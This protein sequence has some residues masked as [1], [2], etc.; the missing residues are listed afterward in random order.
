MV[1]EIDV[2]TPSGLVVTSVITTRSVRDLGLV[3]GKKSLPWS[4]PPRSHRRTLTFF[5]RS[6]HHASQRHSLIPRLNQPSTR[7]LIIPGLRNS[8]EGHWQSWLQSQYRGSRRVNQACWHTADLDA[9]ATRIGETI[10]QTGRHTQWVAVAHSF[11]CLALARYL[12]QQRAAGN[13]I[14][15]ARPCSSPPPI[16][17]SSMWCTDCHKRAWA[18]PRF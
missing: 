18:F 6:R 10:Q 16:Q 14:K 11:G 4:S 2:E 9:W 1:S 3:P 5:R 13:R 8:E 7:V 12:D 17:S 15:L